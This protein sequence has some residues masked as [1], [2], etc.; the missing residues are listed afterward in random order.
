MSKTWLKNKH[1]LEYEQNKSYN[2]GLISRDGKRGDE[3]GVYVK[4]CFKYKIL[5][6]D[7]GHIWIELTYRNKN[8]SVLVGVFYQDN[9]N[10]TSKTE[11]LGMFDTMMGQV[12]LK[13]YKTVILF[14]DLNI[15]IIKVNPA[16]RLYHDI[17]KG[18]D[19]TQHITQPTMNNC[20]IFYIQYRVKHTCVIQC[21][22]I[23]ARYCPYIIIDTKSKPFEPRYKIIRLA[24]D[25]DQQ[26]YKETFAALP[27]TTIFAL[28]DPED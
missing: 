7:I 8:S 24:K 22:E 20:A 11:W 23:G 6:L 27:F 17:L 18:H 9:F 21:P 1:L 12:L 15:D 4:D 28:N 26:H 13:W 25:F 10:N 3:V 2:R 14:G 16:Y 19:L 5:E